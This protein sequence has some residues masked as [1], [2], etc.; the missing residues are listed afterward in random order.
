MLT[1]DLVELKINENAETIANELSNHKLIGKKFAVSTDSFKR[2]MI[3]WTWFFRELIEEGF[4]YDKAIEIRS[5]TIDDAQEYGTY[6]AMSD[7][8]NDL[9]V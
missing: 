3:A 4:T 9:N 8:L 5:A 6:I 1:P 2:G 7:V